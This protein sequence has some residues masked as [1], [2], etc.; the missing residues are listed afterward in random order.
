M[1][2]F[3]SL[4]SVLRSDSRRGY[5]D[6]CCHLA[7]PSRAPPCGALS[8]TSPGKNAVLRC[9]IVR[10]TS[11]R[12]GQGGFAVKGP[13]ATLRGAL[14]RLLVHRPAASG[15]ASSPRFVASAQLHFPSFV[16]AY[17]REDS[18]LRDSAHAGRTFARRSVAKRARRPP[19]LRSA[20]DR[21]ALRTHDRTQSASIQRA[22]RDPSTVVDL[23]PSSRPG[24]RRARS[25]T[26]RRAKAG[27]LP[28]GRVSIA[29]LSV[30]RRQS[31]GDT[32]THGGGL[33]GY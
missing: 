24:G 22:N 25:A 31:V 30:F 2:E 1:I 17:L 20:L 9:T 5:Y 33:N 29:F 7:A 16:L 15:P 6:L 14:Y 32:E 11:R 21:D 3:S 18:H 27:G 8:E 19:G 10:C 13:L 23:T 12:F 4:R 28:S 26:L